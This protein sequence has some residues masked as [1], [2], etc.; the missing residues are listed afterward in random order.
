MKILVELSMTIQAYPVYDGKNLLYWKDTEAYE[1]FKT[2]S[3][4]DSEGRVFLCTSCGGRLQR[5]YASDS[6]R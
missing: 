5:I 6:S 3:F 2:G 1:D 4:T